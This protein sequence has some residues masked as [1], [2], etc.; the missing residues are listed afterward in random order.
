MAQH[1]ERCFL[2]LLVFTITVATTT[3]T[4]RAQQLMTPP[5]WRSTPLPDPLH[6]VIVSTI[7][8]ETWDHVG[9]PSHIRIVE[10]WGVAVVTTTP[11]T[12]SQIET[13]LAT[14]RQVRQQQE[15]QASLPE[16]V[17]KTRFV[18]NAASVFARAR[19]ETALNSETEIDS[20]D[21]PLTEIVVYLR[22][23][24]GIP[25]EIDRTAL[26]EVGVP[27]DAPIRKQLSNVSLRSALTLVLHDLGL[28]YHIQN[29]V[30][31]I[32]TP[33]VAEQ[34]LTTRVYP[35]RDL[36]VNP[37]EKKAKKKGDMPQSPGA[38]EDRG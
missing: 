14:I 22:D 20:I 29:E 9:G 15:E 24:H 34:T 12:H 6:D 25:I 19:I 32:T 21:T 8:P 2:A 18:E 31:Q 7:C 38:I 13:L 11:E 36:L 37:P 23:R 3:P 16:A 33:D 27:E 26:E 1:I 4:V 30:L 5:A 35:V 17:T 10:A 28:T